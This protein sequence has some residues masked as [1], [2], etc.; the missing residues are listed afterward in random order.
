M[1]RYFTVSELYYE[2]ESKT[3]G[4]NEKKFYFD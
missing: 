1:K 3:G 2:V 4:P